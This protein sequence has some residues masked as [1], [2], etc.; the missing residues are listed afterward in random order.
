MA[1]ELGWV[2][3]RYF[4]SVVHY[5]GG[6][7]TDRAGWSANNQDAI[8]FARADDAA[9]VLGWLLGGDGRVTQHAWVVP[10]QKDSH[11]V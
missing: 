8:R 6:R 3:E 1:D 9:N 11:D 5:W 10:A 4:H 2:I 7:A